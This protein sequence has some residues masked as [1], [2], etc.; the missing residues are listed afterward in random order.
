MSSENSTDS[1][2]QTADLSIDDLQALADKYHA[3]GRYQEAA[4]MR[5]AA[6]ELLRRRLNHVRK[7]QAS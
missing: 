3:A 2:E 5:A 7:S 1:G 4:E 6:L